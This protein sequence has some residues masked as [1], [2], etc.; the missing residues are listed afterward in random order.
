MGKITF[1][2]LAVATI[3]L[4]PLS[5]FAFHK[6]NEI[7][8]DGKILVCKDF[9]QI[10]KDNKILVYK[11]NQTKNRGTTLG[12][13]VDEFQLP[14][15][16]MIVELFHRDF[17]DNGKKFSKYHDLKLGKGTVVNFDF[18]GKEINSYATSDGKRSL[19]IVNTGK[20]TNDEA[21]ELQNNCIV[22]QPDG[23]IQPEEITSIEFE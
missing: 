19:P 6:V 16:G 9:N 15:T 13:Q 17:H 8:P 18:S 2:S 1:R 20:L 14:Q 12:M 3:L 10:V 22:I 5:S 11:L 23:Q 7:L 4:L 21:K